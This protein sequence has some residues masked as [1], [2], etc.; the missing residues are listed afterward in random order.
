MAF[1]FI[2]NYKIIQILL[3]NQ[4]IGKN[5]NNNVDIVLKNIILRSLMNESN[6][7]ITLFY[8]GYLFLF[9]CFIDILFNF[10]LKKEILLKIKKIID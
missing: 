5:I 1:I 4:I 6:I 7:K 3:H 2:D 8:K 10:A 9:C